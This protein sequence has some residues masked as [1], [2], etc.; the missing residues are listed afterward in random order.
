MTIS[1]LNHGWYLTLDNGEPVDGPFLN[2]AEAEFA[3]TFYLEDI[4]WRRYYLSPDSLQIVAEVKDTPT[5]PKRGR[6]WKQVLK[7]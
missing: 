1:L 3:R 7:P 4:H 6:T 5:N 2:R